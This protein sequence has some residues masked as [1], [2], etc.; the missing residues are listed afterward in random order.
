MM[1]QPAIEDLIVGLLAEEA[2]LSPA[3]LRRQL[4][5]SG[6]ELP[7]DSVLAAEVL[8]RVE[9]FS[10][11]LLPPTD[12]TA[13]SLRSVRAFA[14]LVHRLMREDAGTQAAGEGA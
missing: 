14:A 11:V 1:D 3:E 9:E 5:E 6:E 12:Q 7:V 2:G 10:G 13:Q 8:A 4:E